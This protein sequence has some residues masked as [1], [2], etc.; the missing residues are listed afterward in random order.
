M[1]RRSGPRIPSA[2]LDTR[3]TPFSL[4]KTMAR[5]TP[6]SWA[7]VTLWWTDHDRLCLVLVPPSATTLSI[8]GTSSNLQFGHGTPGGSA[9]W[10]RNPLGRQLWQRIWPNT[11]RPRGFRSMAGNTAKRNFVAVRSSGPLTNSPISLPSRTPG[12]KVPP[13]SRTGS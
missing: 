2:G 10:G 12:K 5:L 8:T 6:E 9:F 7:A 4:P 1:I 3:L 13:A 11:S